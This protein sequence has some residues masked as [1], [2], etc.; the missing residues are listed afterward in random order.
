MTAARIELAQSFFQYPL[1]EFQL[2]AMATIEAGDNVIVCAPTGAGKTAVAEYAIERALQEG[3][4]CFYTT[5]LK[6]LSNQKY[7]DFC[8]QFGDDA[9]GLLTGDVSVSRNAKIVVMTTEVYRNMLYGTSLGDVQRSLRGVR[10]VILDECHYMNDVD[11]G[12]V[13]EESVIYSPHE[14]Q[15][16]ALSATIAN[17]EELCSWISHTHAKTRLIRTDYRPVP[18][19]HLYFHRDLLSPLLNAKG[20][21]NDHLTK[22]SPFVVKGNVQRKVKRDEP[23]ATPQKVVEELY[24]RDL[25]PAIYF[26]F[27]RRGCENAMFNCD[28]IKLTMEESQKLE[29]YI[30]VAI[31]ENPSLAQHP[32][33]PFLYQGLACHHAGL[34]PS[35]KALVEKLYQECLI[36]VVFAT[37]TLAAGINMPAR[38]TVIGS[39]S[40]YAGDGH[41]ILTSSEFLQM[42][43]RAGRRGM[44]TVGHV[45]TLFHPK[46]SVLSSFKLA[47]SNSDPLESNFRPSYGMVLNL[48]QRHSPEKCRDLVERSFGQFL[49]EKGQKRQDIGTAKKQIEELSGHICPDRIGDL[50]LYRKWSDRYRT[51]LHQSQALGQAPQ[52]AQTRREID[53]IKAQR[54]DINLTMESS[55]C[56]GCRVQVPCWERKSKLH[57]LQTWVRNQATNNRAGSTPYWDKFQGLTAVLQELGYLD[58]NR[59]TK[60]GE[61]AA[62]LRANNIVL[63]TEAV[64]CGELDDLE[65]SEFAALLTCMVNDDS[66]ALESVKG[67]V[68]GRLTEAIQE[69]QSIAKSLDRLQRRHGLEVSTT[70][71]PNYAPIVLRWAEGDSWW[72]VLEWSGL[73]AGDLVRALRRTLDVARQLCFAPH[74]PRWLAQTCHILERQICRNELKESLEQID[75]LA[76]SQMPEDDTE[77]QVAEDDTDSNESQ[78]TRNPEG[79]LYA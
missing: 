46:E 68:G 45:V 72:D 58:G 64:F 71:V 59:P 43:G 70:I 55:P 23:L 2:Q 42:S 22:V 28:G 77:N 79:D 78:A 3:Q 18:L 40:K 1:D 8:K 34:L 27:S 53:R 65:P 31:R 38:T 74:C 26:V 39:L 50:V 12:T 62:A 6:A 66:R 51:L 15:L 63:L 21:L 69:C 44:D 56:H 25:L 30:D 13:W 17:A 33:L 5:P 16:V 20:Q 52:N 36:K 7:H 37:E 61:T 14:V 4:R 60:L 48:L 32:H 49:V 76:F 35:W 41:R 11:R 54:Q 75:L 9:V 29:R 47:K 57:Q 24:K 10:S 67:K 19:K 73:E